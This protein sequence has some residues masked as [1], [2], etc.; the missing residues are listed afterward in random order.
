MCVEIHQNSVHFSET[1]DLRGHMSRFSWK[2]N[3]FS[4][5]CPWKHNKCV[6]K[7]SEQGLF[8]WDI[9]FE[10]SHAWVYCRNECFPIYLLKNP[11][12]VCWNFQNRAC[13]SETSQFEGLQASVYS[14]NECFPI[15]LKRNPINVCWNFQNSVHFSKINDLR[16]HMSRFSWKINV[17][18]PMCLKTQ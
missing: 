2:I 1:N 14:K 8:F 4:N 16:G 9:C 3:M 7:P 17:F 15:Y 13:F 11:I 12:N 6:L 10:G 18:P 5:L